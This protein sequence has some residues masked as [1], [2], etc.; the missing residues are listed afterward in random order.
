MRR[1]VA[2]V[3]VTLTPE[4]TVHNKS[5]SR[6]RQVFALDCWLRAK[7]ERPRPLRNVRKQISATLASEIERTTQQWERHKNYTHSRSGGVSE[8]DGG[9]GEKVRRDVTHTH[10]WWCQQLSS[11]Q[12]S[13]RTQQLQQALSTDRRTVTAETASR[14]R[15]KKTRKT[16]S[17]HLSHSLSLSLTPPLPLPLSLSLSHMGQRRTVG[18][19]VAEDRGGSRGRCW[20]CWMP[21]RPVQGVGGL[22]EVERRGGGGR[23]AVGVE[24]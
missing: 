21:S 5:Q 14:R 12:H 6:R 18:G 13:A 15:H 1:Q 24:G 23:T 3:R 4:G 17:T 11:A 7:F 2:Y 19:R 8:Y 10:Q 20:W 9:G 22:W 16:H